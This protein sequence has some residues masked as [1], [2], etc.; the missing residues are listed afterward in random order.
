MS[1][2]PFRVALTA[3]FYNAGELRY[4]DIGLDLFAGQ[5]R[6]AVTSFAEHRPIVEPQQLAGVN[7]AIVLTPRVTTE[8]LTQSDNLLAIA[9]FGVGY[10]SVDVAACTAAGVMLTITTGAVDSSVA[11]AT[12]CWMLALGHHLRTKDQLVRTGE[13]D[14]RSRF[15][16]SELRER[17]IG[18]IG[19]GGIGRRVLKMLS[20]FEIGEPLVFDPFVAPEKI[21]EAGAKPVTLDELLRASDYV[22]LHCPLSDQT[23]NLLSARELALMKPTAYL[24]NT[25]RGGIVNEDVLF[26]ALKERQI[27]GAALDCFVDEPLT[28]PPRWAELDNV[29]LAPHSIAWTHELFRDIGRCCCQGL[30]LLSQGRKPTQGIVNPEVLDHP[31]FQAKWRRLTYSA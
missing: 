8:S 20:G 26:I 27:A 10:D 28:A 6:F 2:V 17:T 11:E 22:S 24:L 30:I 23:R 15:M 9:R 5:P 12:V 29:L 18:L 31:M 7:G 25:A 14:L 1:D 13:W 4:R 3:D 21:V 16:G 19:F